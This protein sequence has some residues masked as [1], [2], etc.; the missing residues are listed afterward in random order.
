MLTQGATPEM[1][2]RWKEIWNEYK[3]KLIPNRK[4]SKEFME[5]FNDKYYL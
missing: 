1:V 5:Y 4:T 2:E 3:G